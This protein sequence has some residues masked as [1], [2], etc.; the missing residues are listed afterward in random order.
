MKAIKRFVQLITGFHRIHD[1]FNSY[2]YKIPFTKYA[3][4]DDFGFKQIYTKDGNPT[5]HNCTKSNIY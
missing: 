3:Y 5:F 4:F 1:I 2:G